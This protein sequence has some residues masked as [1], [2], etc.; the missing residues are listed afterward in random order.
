MYVCMHVCVC[1][2]V[3]V[4]V[5]VCV[6]VCVCVLA[7][8]RARTCIY[9]SKEGGKDQESIQVSSTPSPG[10]HILK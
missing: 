8:V 2:C 5:R 1:V 9:L 4:R 3:C 10:H 7:C 6:C